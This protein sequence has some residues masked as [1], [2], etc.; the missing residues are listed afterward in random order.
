MSRSD[1]LLSETDIR[2]RRAVVTTVKA[3]ARDR[4]P[5]LR[6]AAVCGVLANYQ[7]VHLGVAVMPAPFRI[8]RTHLGGSYFLATLGGAGRVLVDGR[9]KACRTG[10]AFLL[11]PGTLHAFHAPTSGRWEFCWVRYQEKPGQRP[12]ATASS[13]VLARFDAA[14][15]RDAILGLHHEC[16]HASLPAAIDRWLELIQLYVQSFARPAGMDRRL[17][18]LWDKVASDLGQRWTSALM[19]REVHLSEKHLERLC[20]RELGRTPRQQLIWL[21]MRRA[22]ELLTAGDTKIGAVAAEVGYQNPFVFSR[23][24]KRIMGWSPSRYPAGPP[25]AVRTS[26]S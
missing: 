10:Q 3:D 5:W 12:L 23:T 14:P 4:R 9:W 11:P 16:L 21:R 7:I 22:A 17:W 20:L 24:F 6:R 25:G 13:P 19:A 2:S 26:V 18:K 15:L 1:R 8:V